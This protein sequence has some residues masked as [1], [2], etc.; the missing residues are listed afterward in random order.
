MVASASQGLAPLGALLA[1]DPEAREARGWFYQLAR[2]QILAHGGAVEGVPWSET[3]AEHS[4]VAGWG[5][6]GAAQWQALREQEGALAA[7]P[8]EHPLGADARWLRAAWRAEI[9]D[10]SEAGLLLDPLLARGAD[11]VEWYVTRARAHARAGEVAPAL[12]ALTEMVWAAGRRPIASAWRR[13]AVDLLS[14]LAPDPEWDAWR[15]SL[16]GVLGSN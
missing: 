2:P 13:Q 3:P 7:I 14:S 10:A 11:R 9:G 5:E 4:V 6:L 1:R 12:G 8:L 16:V 15:A